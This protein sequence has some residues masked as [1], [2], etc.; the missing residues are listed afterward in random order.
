MNKHEIIAGKAEMK[1]DSGI[2]DPSGRLYYLD[3]LR[4]FA[5]LFVLMVHCSKIFDYHTTVVFNSVRSPVLSIL[6]EYVL[7]WIMP[8]FF[9]VSGAAVFLSSRFQKTKGSI[10]SK[11]KRL[12]IPSVLIGTFIV[13]PVYVYIE[14]L[15]N[16]HSIGGFFQWYPHFF[17]GIYGFG[18][19]NFAPW[20]MGTHLWYLQ[21]LFIY[22]LIFLPLFIRS[23]KSGVSLLERVS[24]YFKNPWA[25]FFLFLPVS[26][27]AAAFEY[28]GLSGIRIMG[29]WDPVS[30][31][32]FFVYGYLI[33][34]NMEIQETIK[35]YS[36]IFLIVALVVTALYLASHFGVMAKI[37]GITRHDLTTGATLPP[38]H[39]GFAVVQAFRG[40]MAWC[41]ALAFLGL[42]RRFLNFNNKLRAYSNE[43]VLPFY[44]LH[45]P[46]IYIVGF[47]VIQWSSGVGIKFF[48]ISIVSFTMIM[49]IY[50]IFIRRVNILRF[51]FGM[52]SK[53]RSKPIIESAASD[54][55][56]ERFDQPSY[57]RGNA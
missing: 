44:I 28:N 49:A 25:L 32:L 45:H 33:Y 19:G 41:W 1:S 39:S 29:N 43:A 50:E 55:K 37:Q 5:I 53:S 24:P 18:K 2:L 7:L 8:F 40:L 16:D 3:W 23:K 42:G 11:F 13:N 38:D 57:S 34:S 27:I 22:S 51:L 48:V 15:F 52:K 4:V 21:F 17:N 54:S 12:L 46:V 26:T 35:K 56:Y 14:R 47:S 6:R 36:S 9:I 10:K 31:M 20:G 30:Y